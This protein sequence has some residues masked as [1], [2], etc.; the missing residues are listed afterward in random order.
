MPSSIDIRRR[1]W[2]QLRHHS[3]L[4]LTEGYQRMEPA[5]YA[6]WKEPDITGEICVNIQEFLESPESPE[7]VENYALRDDPKLNVPDKYGE[8]RPR[9]DIEFELI[10]R[11]ERPKFRFEAKRLGAKHPVS[12]Y[13]GSEGLGAFLDGYYPLSYPMC[14]MLGYVQ[15]KTTTIWRTKLQA[16]LNKNPHNYQFESKLGF[17]ITTWHHELE[18]WHTTHKLPDFDLKVSHTLLEFCVNTEKYS[19]EPT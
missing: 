8:S 7:W 2:E 3:H 19:F 9:I 18:S 17:E 14:G 10:R 5:K 13:L 11:G 15:S 16:E 12:K 6:N 4:L 1:A